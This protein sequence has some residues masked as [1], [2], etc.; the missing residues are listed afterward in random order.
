LEHS[1]CPFFYYPFPRNVLDDVLPWN[2][3]TGLPL[4]HIC[5][6]L[7]GLSLLD[8]AWCLKIVT[9]VAWLQMLLI[10]TWQFHRFHQSLEFSNARRS[11]IGEMDDCPAVGKYI[12]RRSGVF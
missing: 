4:P 9:N 11:R 2:D 8:M 3:I 12:E 6:L 5:I 1:I 7:Y 10:K